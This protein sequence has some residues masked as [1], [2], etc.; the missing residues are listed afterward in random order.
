MNQA[1]RAATNGQATDAPME[2][3]DWV[4]IA[5][6]IGFWALYLLL[7]IVVI[8]AAGTSSTTTY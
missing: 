5:I 7:I 3:I 1:H 2:T 8:V 6:G 4:F